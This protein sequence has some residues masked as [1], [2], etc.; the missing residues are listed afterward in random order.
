L[1]GR[2]GVTEQRGEPKESKKELVKGS[3]HFGEKSDNSHLGVRPHQKHSIHH[4]ATICRKL[5]KPF[6]G[7]GGGH[8]VPTE[9]NPTPDGFHKNPLNKQILTSQ[10]GSGIYR[11]KAQVPKLV[12]K[13]QRGGGNPKPIKGEQVKKGE[14]QKKGTVLGYERGGQETTKRERENKRLSIRLKVTYIMGIEGRPG[15]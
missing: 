12:P 1:L 3:G 2:K 5:Y 10:R 7:G 9:E 8:W 4:L 13:S 6:R 11:K 15:G 14:R